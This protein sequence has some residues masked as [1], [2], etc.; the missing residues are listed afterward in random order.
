LK[1]RLAELG[2][3]DRGGVYRTKVNCLRICADGPIAIVYPDGVWYR[4]CTPVVLERIIQEHLIGGRPVV[5]YAF[6]TH[7]LGS[8]K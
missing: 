3:A 1:K 5:E 8:A 4:S 7:A 6:V 2:L